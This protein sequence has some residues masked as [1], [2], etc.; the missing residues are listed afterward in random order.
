MWESYK[1]NMRNIYS[2]KDFATTI[3]SKIATNGIAASDEPIVVNISPKP[4]VRLPTTVSNGGSWNGGKPALIS[5]VNAN[6]AACP[7]RV[8][9]YAINDPMNTANAFLPNDTYFAAPAYLPRFIS[10]N[11]FN[12]NKKPIVNTPNTES[13]SLALPTFPQMCIHASRNSVDLPGNPSN[14]FTCKLPICNAAAVVKPAVTG[15]EMNCTKLPMFSR[16]NVMMMQPQMNDAKT[17]KSG[18]NNAKRCTI[19]AIIAVGP[20]VTFL[21]LPTT[22]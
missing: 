12:A 1:I 5:P 14:D 21:L 6:G 9:T 17:A 16:P 19:S 3:T 15:I 10:P 13:H 8:N 11:R 22:Q 7:S 4:N 20:I 18:L 2:P